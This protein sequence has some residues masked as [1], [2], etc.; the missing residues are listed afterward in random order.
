VAIV[1]WLAG[2][3]VLTMVGFVAEAVTGRTP[4]PDRVFTDPVLELVMLLVLLALAIPAVLGAARWPQRRPPGTVSSVAG[5]LR[6]RWLG[7]CLGLAAIAIILMYALILVLLA[8]SGGAADEE[9]DFGWV[10]WEDFI[11]PALV[12]V[13]LVPLQAAGEEYAFR[14]WIVQFFGA[15]LRSPY[16]GIAVSALMFAI[17]HGIGTTWGFADLMLFGFVAGWLVVRTGG[18][19][20]AIA[21]HAMNNV[22]AFLLATAAGQLDDQ[23]TAADSPWQLFAASLVI[24]PAYALTVTLIARRSRVASRV[25]ASPEARQRPDT[26]FPETSDV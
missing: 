8:V 4:L 22:P 26:T 9:L 13:A 5:R 12:C 25:P 10:G 2:A 3:A 21:L 23:S 16:A 18:L 17:A 20:A 14:G 24:L 11:V 6:W 19:E 15:Y 7:T 1:L